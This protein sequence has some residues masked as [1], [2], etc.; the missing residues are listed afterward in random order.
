MQFRQ[1]PTFQKNISPP[2]SGWKS[3]L[4]QKLPEAGGKLM[5]MTVDISMGRSGV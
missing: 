5:V 3:D 1:I 2:Y 4:S